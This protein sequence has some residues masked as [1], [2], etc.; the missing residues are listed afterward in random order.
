MCSWVLSKNIPS[1]PF[2]FDVF[3]LLRLRLFSRH[4]RLIPDAAVRGSCEM[5]GNEYKKLDNIRSNV[6]EQKKTY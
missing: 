5:K 3:S 4:A 6:M 1:Q 2:A